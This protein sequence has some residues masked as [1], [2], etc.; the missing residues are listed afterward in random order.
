MSFQ[1]DSTLS[2]VIKVQ[3]CSKNWVKNFKRRGFNGVAP[4]LF[5]F[6]WYVSTYILRGVVVNAKKA[7]S[8]IHYKKYCTLK[9]T[10]I[11]WNKHRHWKR[12][13]LWTANHFNGI[14]WIYY[15]LLRRMLSLC[16]NT[17]PV[18]RIWKRKKGVLLFL[19][20]VW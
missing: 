19:Y 13:T 2:R 4:L 18:L 14:E 7:H 8:G 3:S 6:E 12:T 15:H 16:R 1:K 5:Y 17:L 20:V 11:Q 9:T 10:Y